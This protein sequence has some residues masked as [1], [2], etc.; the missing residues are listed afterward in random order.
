MGSSITATRLPDRPPS[1]R[2]GAGPQHRRRHHRRPFVRLFRRRP[3]LHRQ[4]AA[5]AD[6]SLDDAPQAGRASLAPPEAAHA[7]DRTGELP[8]EA[9]IHGV[10]RPRR[11]DVVTS[12]EATG[13]AGDSVRFVAL[14]DGTLL[15]TEDEPDDALMPLADAVERSIRPPYRAE[16]VR[17]EGDAWSVAATRVA[18]VEVRGLSGDAAELVVNRD[19]RSLHVDGRSTLGRAP[20]LE[21]VGE[22]H[23]TEYVVRASRVDGDLWEVEATAL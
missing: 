13:L 2:D 1:S 5:A 22:A 15:V 8:G 17:R 4:L 20:A 16:A 10:P 19:G 3:P 14:A 12:A 23:A 6:L 7:P 21:R 18:I 9:G 11:W